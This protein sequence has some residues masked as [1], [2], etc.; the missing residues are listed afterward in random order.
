MFLLGL[1][2]L[3]VSAGACGPLLVSAGACGPLLVS[4]GACGP[5][6]VSAG[7]PADGFGRGIG[8]PRKPEATG[9]LNCD[10]VFMKSGEAGGDSSLVLLVAEPAQVKEDR[11]R[12]TM[13]DMSG[14]PGL[15]WL[16]DCAFPVKATERG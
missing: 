9:K 11:D 6:L 3:L 15:V 16:T 14:L 7:P 12:G 5:L 4:T 1:W 2:T 10:S 13:V 8:V